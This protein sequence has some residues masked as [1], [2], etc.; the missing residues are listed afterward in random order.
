MASPACEMA[1]TPVTGSMRIFGSA[2]G[3]VP[4]TVC[5]QCGGSPLT[6][7][8]R[9]MPRGASRSAIASATPQPM[10]RPAAQHAP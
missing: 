8:R 3:S 9:T 2:S 5:S 4:G 6:A 10:P 1:A 7:R